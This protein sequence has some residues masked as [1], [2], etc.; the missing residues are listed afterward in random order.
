MEVTAPFLMS[1]SFMVFMFLNGELE[2][3][4]EHSVE[5]INA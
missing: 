1:Y 5:V 3:E 2:V 4:D